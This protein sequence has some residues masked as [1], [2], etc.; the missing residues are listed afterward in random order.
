RCSPEFRELY[1]S[2]EPLLFFADAGNGDQFAFAITGG[3]VR[4]PDI[5]VW[6]HENDSRAWVA[7]S[8]E[9]YLEWWLLGTLKL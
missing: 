2:F 7:P 6:H 8:L 4:R 1:M 5:F 9:R 3:V